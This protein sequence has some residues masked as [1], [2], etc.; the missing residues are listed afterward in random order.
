MTSLVSGIILQGGVSDRDG[1]KMEPF[2]SQISQMV[3]E[4]NKLESEKKEKSI[5]STRFEQLAL[6]TAAPFML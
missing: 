6:I 1:M 5:L 4:A 2:A 3:A